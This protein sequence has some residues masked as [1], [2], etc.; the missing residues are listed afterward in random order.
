MSKEVIADT[1][2]IVNHEDQKL[3]TQDSPGEFKHNNGAPFLQDDDE[4][5]DF[6]ADG[7]C[8]AP[9]GSRVF[10]P[11]NYYFRYLIEQTGTARTMTLLWRRRCGSIPGRTMTMRKIST[12]S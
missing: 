7:C 3:E 4:F 12:I 9:Q 1:E 6:V 2:D 11:A 8:S 5:K 10:S